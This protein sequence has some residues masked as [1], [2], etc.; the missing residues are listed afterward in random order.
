MMGSRGGL[1][2]IPQCS[3]RWWLQWQSSRYGSSGSKGSTSEC[4]I[5]H[6]GIVTNRLLASDPAKLTYFHAEF[7]GWITSIE[8]EELGTTELTIAQEHLDNLFQ[9]SDSKGK[10]FLDLVDGDDNPIEPSYTRGGSWLKFFGHSNSL[11][12]RA[13]RAIT[14]H[15]PIGEYRIRFFPREDFSC[16]CGSYPIES[17]HHI[18][19]ECRRFNNYWNPRRDLISHFVLFLEFNPGAFAFRN[20]SI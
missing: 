8:L 19:H 13:S 1:C 3:M 5:F 10:H 17:R 9:A 20:V 11:C 6:G 18:L 7:P 4:K 14:N 15:A 16:P 12:A 2:S